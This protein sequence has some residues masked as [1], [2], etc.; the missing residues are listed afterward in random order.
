MAK[1]IAK[2]R[3]GDWFAMTRAG[4]SLPCLKDQYLRPHGEYHEPCFYDPSLSKN[5]EY[6][7]AIQRGRV[8]IATYDTSQ[9]PHKRTG[10]LGYVYSV[11]DI[12]HDESGLRCRVV[13]KQRP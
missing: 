4:E 5:A 11:E 12:R 7:A 9:E 10:Y 1:K 8:L 13:G 6:V 3:Q 2:G